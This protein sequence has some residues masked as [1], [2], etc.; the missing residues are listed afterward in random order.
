M[1]D[2]EQCLYVEEEYTLENNSSKEIPAE[3]DSIRLM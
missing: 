2:I 3:D 1:I